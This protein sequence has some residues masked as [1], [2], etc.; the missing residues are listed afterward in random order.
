MSLDKTIRENLDGKY[1]TIY[2]DNFNRG[3]EYAAQIGINQIHLIGI[4]GIENIIDFKEFAKISDTLKV[5]SFIGS[6]ENII[7]FESIYLLKNVEKIYFQQKQKFA[8]DISKFTQIKHLGSEYWKGLTNFNKAHSL[9]SMVFFKFTDMNLKKISEL[10]KLQILHIYS[11]KIQ[12]L[13]GIETLPITELSLVRNNN[14]ENI[15]AIKDLK[16]LKELNI[17]RCKKIV[18]YKLIDIIKNKVKVSII[19]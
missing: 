6:V 8:I 18:D 3:I 14:L 17:E 4:S 19:R 13:N 5:L 7:N 2:T 15:Q 16:M 12:T 1:L 10:R 9:K 11:S